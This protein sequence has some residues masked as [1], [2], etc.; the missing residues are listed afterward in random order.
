MSSAAHTLSSPSSALKAF[1]LAKPI[2]KNIY[3]RDFAFGDKIKPFLDA[4]EAVPVSAIRVSLYDD[5]AKSALTFNGKE[6]I[7]DYDFDEIGAAFVS[8]FDGDRLVIKDCKLDQLQET[9]SGF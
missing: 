3:L 4:L 6:F 5:G 9:L 8:R 7:V 1:V 2:Y